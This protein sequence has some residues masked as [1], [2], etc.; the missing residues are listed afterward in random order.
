MNCN[1]IDYK[2]NFYCP[3]TKE[4]VTP[5]RQPSMKEGVLLLR[6]KLAELLISPPVLSDYLSKTLIEKFSALNP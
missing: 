5:S 3:S 2:K 4:N 1:L 6:W